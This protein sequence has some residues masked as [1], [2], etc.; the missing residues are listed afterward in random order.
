MVLKSKHR[1]LFKS[2]DIFG[3]PIKLEFDKKGSTH[4]TCCGSIATIVFVLI[5]LGIIS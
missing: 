2:L 1:K 3:H 4:K 5:S